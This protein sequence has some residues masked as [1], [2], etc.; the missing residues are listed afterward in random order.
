MN[1]FVALA[2][3]CGLFLTGCATAPQTMNSP[4][5]WTLS[6]HP[7]PAIEYLPGQLNRESLFDLLSAEIAG[8]RGLFDE[9]LEKYLFQASLTRDVAVAERAT[10]IAQFMRD[11]SAV[12][13]AAQIWSLADPQAAEPRRLVASILLH[14][15]RFSEALPLLRDLLMD[16][17]GEADALLLIS[18]Q[19]EALSVEVA[20]QYL[21]LLNEISAVQPERLDLFLARG[22]LY[23]R[24]NEPELALQMFDLGLRQQPYQPQ[25]VLQKSDILLQLGRNNEALDLLSRA[26]AR[27]P[28]QQPLQIQY[29]RTLLELGEYSRAERS[30]QQLL[31]RAAHEPQLQLYFALL[32]LDHQRL[33]TSREWLQRLQRQMPENR[34]LEFYLGHIAQ[35]QGQ[36]EIAIGHYQAV[37][38]GATFLQ[39]QARLLELFNQAEHRE[40][41]ESLMRQASLRQPEQSVELTLMLAEWLRK[42]NLKKETQAVLS[43][44]LKTRPNNTRLLYARALSYEPEQPER[45]LRDL[46]R[47]IALEPDSAL[48]QNALGYTLTVYTQDYEEAHALI[49]RALEQEPEDPAI[50]DSMGWVLFKMGRAEKA[51]FFLERAY[52][53]YPDPE[54]SAHLIEVLYSLGR[55][56][57]ALS[58]LTQELAEHPEDRHLLDMVQRLHRGQP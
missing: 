13:E 11:S 51:L 16:E 21:T 1:K 50:L 56:E 40:Q 20:S 8:H 34:D 37:D 36:R 9:A 55:K 23:L 49:S 47:A 10:R 30:I 27:H 57:D 5:E 28:E 35:L 46:R 29:A 58:L 54:V 7:L 24:L 12:L 22:L 38:Q 25:L 42:Q 2:I 15:Q 44:A 32:L 33:D 4:P 39:A 41:V 6:E 19:S 3:S 17:E 53:L 14:Q 45:M 43:E 18:S 52:A 48:L 26:V 31:Q